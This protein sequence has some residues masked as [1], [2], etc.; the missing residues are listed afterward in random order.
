MRVGQW[1]EIE[2]I[3]HA[4]EDVTDADCVWKTSATKDRQQ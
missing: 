1:F 2:V 4:H 3:E